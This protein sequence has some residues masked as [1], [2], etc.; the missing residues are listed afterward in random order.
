L[1]LEL[2]IFLL[3]VPFLPGD[4][5]LMK[6]VSNGDVLFE[7]TLLLL[8]PADQRILGLYRGVAVAFLLDKIAVVIQEHADT[9]FLKLPYRVGTIEESVVIS[10][11][12]SVFPPEHADLVL[13]LLGERLI[14]LFQLADLGL[15]MLA[16]G[17]GM[18]F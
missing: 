11:K 7:V 5:D 18:R 12:F 10:G 3:H 6:L 17:G 2:D 8:E 14:F 1:L 16:H 4:F 9:G 13:F 15:A